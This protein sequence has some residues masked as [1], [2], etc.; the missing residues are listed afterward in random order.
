MVYAI[1]FFGKIATAQMTSSPRWEDWRSATIG[2]FL[3]QV[4]GHGLRVDTTG[5]GWPNCQLRLALDRH[6]LRSKIVATELHDQFGWQ[7]RCICPIHG[8]SA[9]WLGATVGT[10]LHGVDAAAW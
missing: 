8:Q 10:V 4:L 5:H 7:R 2:F 9:A 1:R 6:R 3:P